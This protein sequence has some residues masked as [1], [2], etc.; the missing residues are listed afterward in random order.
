MHTMEV[1][2]EKPRTAD[3]VETRQSR[4]EALEGDAADL[5]ASIRTNAYGITGAGSARPAGEASA[6]VGHV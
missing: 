5:E 3:R 4:I 2:D 1:R 6:S